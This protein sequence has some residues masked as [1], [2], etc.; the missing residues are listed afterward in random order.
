MEIRSILS[1]PK[2][3]VRSPLGIIGLF[4]FLVYGLA[5]ISF[6]ATGEMSNSQRWLL[7]F[8][9]VIF[10]IIVFA[11][12]IGLVLYRPGQLFGPGDFDTDEAFIAFSS[13]FARV[14]S[15]VTITTRSEPLPT[16]ET[17]FDE[18]RRNSDSNRTSST[19]LD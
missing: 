6:T 1:G 3:F 4:T 11:G 2:D 10:P 9:I 17:P 13:G 5:T 16:R 12:F 7:T 14:E 18:R 15:P 8:F 19:R